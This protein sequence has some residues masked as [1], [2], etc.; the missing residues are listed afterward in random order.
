MCCT[1]CF[2]RLPILQAPAGSPPDTW[3]RIPAAVVK[4]AQEL[5][6]NLEDARFFDLYN[7]LMAAATRAIGV[8]QAEHQ[9][10]VA[11]LRQRTAAL[12]AAHAEQQQQMREMQAALQQLLHG[13]RQ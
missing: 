5:V 12:E 9:Q 13:P 7:E 10:E 11:G 6:P 3:C 1:V 2:S 8:V 4:I